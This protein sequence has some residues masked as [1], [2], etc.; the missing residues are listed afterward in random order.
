MTMDTLKTLRDERA[1]LRAR[2]DQGLDALRDTIL[3]DTT[4][5]SATSPVGRLVVTI[6]RQIEEVRNV[7]R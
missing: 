5:W 1:A 6:L 7:L 3:S 4:V 2:I